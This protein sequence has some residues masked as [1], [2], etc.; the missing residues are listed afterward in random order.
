MSL[1]KYAAT[2]VRRLVCLVFL[3]TV[4]AG[5]VSTLCSGV[6][7]ASG[8]LGDVGVWQTTTS[9]PAQI[10]Q[11]ASVSY[12][13]Y[14]Y[15]IGGASGAS[16]TATIYYAPMN[17]DGSVG[18][19][20]TASSSLP[21]AVNNES[22][23]AYN[24]YLY[25]MGGDSASGLRS[26]VYYAPLNSDGSVGAWQTGS[27]LPS[28]VANG[29][30]VEANGYLY[31]F[32]GDDSG[33]LTSAY[34]TKIN[35]DGSVGAWQTGNSLPSGNSYASAA[36]FNGYVYVT[37]GTASGVFYA[38]LN[39]DGS[40]G[41]WQTAGNAPSFD[42]YQLASISNGY[43]IVY[44]GQSDGAVQS[45]PLNANG[46]VGTWTTSPNSMDPTFLN[47]GFEANG[48]IYSLAGIDQNTGL[49]NTVNYAALNYTNQATVHNSATNQPIHIAVPQGDN[50]NCS[51]AS[52]EASQTRL[53]SSYAYP[54]GM[55][56]FCFTTQNYTNKVSLV[57]VTNLTAA[58]VVA[59]DYNPTT[60]RY[61][62]IPGATI[63]QTTY[64][65]SPAL[66]LTYT[67]TD[68]GALDEDGLTN[69]SI[70]DPV[71]LAMSVAVASP[72][73]PNTGFGTPS[74]ADPATIVLAGS[75]I[76]AGVGFA[77]L[78]RQKAASGSRS[79]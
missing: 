76:S 75:L 77:L 79:S 53:D 58:Q 52:S 37:G 26:S 71:G 67:I 2:T 9:L 23:V 40:V 49:R 32:G 35:S 19:W 34:Y 5:A 42:S 1:R 68:G 69:Q 38:T 64:N 65:G 15:V 61:T 29:A 24:G 50:I 22:A 57:F 48:F 45:A 12:N 78:R 66:A 59:R 14:A 47:A 73:A 4:A 20:T 16:W 46:S 3:S 18:S 11:T 44:G 72:A 74:Q 43:L 28:P 21:T 27:S 10:L 51:S 60:G 13:N 31:I 56:R 36:I 63:T 39:A 70:T 6:S 62:T 41:A 25:V 54:L 55:V 30:A 17:S 8:S 33:V 7:Y